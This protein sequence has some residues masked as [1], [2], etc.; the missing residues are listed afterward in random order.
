MIEKIN[1]MFSIVKEKPTITAQEIAQLEEQFPRLPQDHLE[2][3]K[4]ASYLQ[5]Y[6]VN[7][8]EYLEH[9]SSDDLYVIC[10]Y[11]AR[12]V[13]DAETAYCA[14]KETRDIDGD[15][16]AIGMDGGDSVFICMHGDKGWGLYLLNVCDGE[17]TWVAPTLSDLLIHGTG[18]EACIEHSYG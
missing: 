7:G 12:E 9:G 18:I 16:V 10:L 2:A 1:P 6:L 15:A 3:L 4:E 8:S 13:L 11:V 14:V 5:V 17:T